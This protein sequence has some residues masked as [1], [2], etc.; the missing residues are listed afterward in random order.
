MAFL[1][2]ILFNEG[3]E[4]RPGAV[5]FALVLLMA[6]FSL[7]ILQTAIL[8]LSAFDLSAPVWLGDWIEKLISLVTD[9]IH[10]Y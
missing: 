8:L 4:I 6:V 5:T 3:R 2:S 9:R 10:G 1:K 7:F